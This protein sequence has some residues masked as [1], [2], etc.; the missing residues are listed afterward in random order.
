M[1]DARQAVGEYIDL[2]HATP[3]TGHGMNG[4]TP[5]EVWRTAQSLRR[6]KDDELI[7]LMQA[8]GVFKVS[9]NG[10]SFTVGATR[11]SYG[12]TSHKLRRY[13][14]R[15]VFVTVNPANVD[16]AIA[17][18][19]EDRRFI[20]RLE[21]NK[22]IPPNTSAD[23]L[24]EAMA[25][26]GRARKA[27]GQ[28]QRSEAQRMRTAAQQV[29]ASR[30]EQHAELKATGT[31]DHRPN[32]TVVHTGFEGA[33]AEAIQATAT[34]SV[35]R[36]RS[37][38]VAE[39]KDLWSGQGM[40]EPQPTRPRVTDELLFGAKVSLEDEGDTDNE[41]TDAGKSDLLRLIA[42]GDRHERSDE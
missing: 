28:A 1:D 27:K 11:M 40:A 12:A 32:V 4:R 16:H 21:A 34:P 29:A 19:A 3:H 26:V 10:V 17:W 36:T 6:A 24:R 8:R 35:D 41:G 25:T 9:G 30:R 39:A 5:I 23:E 42:E 22:R 18:T 13:V 2:Y 7:F 37:A 38:M 33:S 15:E 31:E 20:D 14:G